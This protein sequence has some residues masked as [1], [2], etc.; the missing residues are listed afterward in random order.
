MAAGEA[1]RGHLRASHADREH[2]IATLKAAFVQGR[3]TKD[4]LDA[5]AGQT[6]AARTYADL[7]AL[8]ADLPAALTRAQPPRQP[9]RARS[10]LPAKAARAAA[11]VSLALGLL[12]VAS[13]MGPG[14]GPER[15]IAL[16]V[17][18]L[19]LWGS[20]LVTLMVRAWLDKRSH[21]GQLPPRPRQ[22]GRAL[23]GEQNA[24]PDDDAGPWPLIGAQA[25]S[26][27]ARRFPIGVHLYRSAIYCW[28]QH[29]R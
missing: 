16:M 1:S 4:E 15:F 26:G 18:F 13:F 11:C 20:L 3:L 23:E 24:K 5:R 7:A 27:P 9:A 6:F 29:C 2:V 12:A 17:V 14:S 21:R 8:T 25:R 22:G 19:P 28:T 10:Q